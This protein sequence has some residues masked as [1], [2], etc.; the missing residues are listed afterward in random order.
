M[1]CATDP[2]NQPRRLTSQPHHLACAVRPRRAT[3]VVG[4]RRLG[5]KRGL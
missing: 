4:R 5:G 1:V 3:L 2:I